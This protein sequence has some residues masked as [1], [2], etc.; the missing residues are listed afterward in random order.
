M[1]ALRSEATGGACLEGIG[2]MHTVDSAV[3]ERPGGPQTYDN[4]MTYSTP[5]VITDK[6]HPRT[7]TYACHFLAWE[8]GLPGTITL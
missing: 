7:M 6:K 5:H 8:L 3:T 2:N 4:I 1:Q